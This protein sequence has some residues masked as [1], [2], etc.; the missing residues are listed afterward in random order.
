[1]LRDVVQII[2]VFI[3][4]FLLLNYIDPA[5]YP[6]FFTSPITSLQYVG[7]NFISS[8]NQDSQ[9]RN[10]LDVTLPYWFPLGFKLE[11]VA[12]AL[13]GPLLLATVGLLSVASKI[14]FLWYMGILIGVFLVIFGAIITSLSGAVPDTT[15]PTNLRSILL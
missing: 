12:I 10:S 2:T 8:F 9:Y 1:M 13:L 6:S 15:I 7:L 14:F 3:Q 11:F 4:Y 5:A